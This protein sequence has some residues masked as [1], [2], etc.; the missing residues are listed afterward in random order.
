MGIG[1]QNESN[2][3]G[4]EMKKTTLAKRE[5]GTS[6]YRVQYDAFYR[7]YSVTVERGGC[8]CAGLTYY[9]DDKADAFETMDAMIADHLKTTQA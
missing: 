6:V 2:G 1:Q 5:V 7:E 4:I 9:G 8:P 3:E